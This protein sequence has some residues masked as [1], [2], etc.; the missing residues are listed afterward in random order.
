M[1]A[2]HKASS[3]S[4]VLTNGQL[5]H[6]AN[7]LADLKAHH[8]VCVTCCHPLDAMLTCCHLLE[9]LSLFSSTV[10]STSAWMCEQHVGANGTMPPTAVARCATKAQKSADSETPPTLF[11]PALLFSSMAVRRSSPC[12]QA[13]WPCSTKLAPHAP[14]RTENTSQKTSLLLA[15]SQA[16]ADVVDICCLNLQQRQWPSPRGSPAS[17][18]SRVIPSASAL[19]PAPSFTPSVLS[20]APSGEFC[21]AAAGHAGRSLYL[22]PWPCRHNHRRSLLWIRRR[23]PFGARTA[24]GLWLSTCARGQACCPALPHQGP[25]QLCSTSSTVCPLSTGRTLASWAQQVPRMVF[26]REQRFQAGARVEIC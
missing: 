21:G 1:S 4:C 23:M 15:W 2:I 22:S 17:G 3:S 5:L 24:Q 25:G 26:S 18:P 8:A 9:E 16:S 10:N 12:A 11:A 14:C 7:S 19:P 13:H 6:Q 20:T